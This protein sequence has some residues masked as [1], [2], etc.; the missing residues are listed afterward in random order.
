MP[1]SAVSYHIEM[2]S[3][4]GTSNSLGLA[5]YSTPRPSWQWIKDYF[6]CWFGHQHA[7]S[8]R[9]SANAMLCFPKLNMRK[10]CRR[11]DPAVNRCLVVPCRLS[12]LPAAVTGRTACKNRSSP[13]ARQRRTG[14]R[15]AI[16]TCYWS[17]WPWPARFAAHPSARRSCPPHPGGRCRSRPR[18][19]RPAIP[20]GSAR[21][22]NC[23]RR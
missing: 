3:Q 16:K 7:L 9:S 21:P 15:R 19:D 8:R 1:R 20:A 10:G 5:L 22:R 13:R 12:F 17:S 14:C 23:L 18:C 6:F 4:H 11:A 2:S